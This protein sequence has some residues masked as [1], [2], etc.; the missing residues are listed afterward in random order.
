M[1]ASLVLLWGWAGL[2]TVKRILLGTGYGL[3]PET[4][5]SGGLFFSCVLGLR[6]CLL[7]LKLMLSESVQSSAE[8]H[9]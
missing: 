6:I 2:A 7:I 8:P 3:T 9:V 5:Q 1:L 4:C